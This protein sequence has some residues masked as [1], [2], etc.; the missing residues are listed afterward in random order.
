MKKC[1]NLRVISDYY[2]IQKPTGNAQKEKTMYKQEELVA[3]K[4]MVT[5]LV[6]ILPGRT[7]TFNTA[8]DD[9]RSLEEMIK[10]NANGNP[11]PGSV[12]WMLK[13][14]PDPAMWNK[15]IVHRNLPKD[16]AESYRA[17]EIRK[18]KIMGY[19]CLNSREN[20]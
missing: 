9:D 11:K 14:Y 5:K 3:E 12:Y 10:A 2:I 7:Y 13:N 6:L 4:H 20:Y 16:V 18:D 17:W 8:R 1:Y 19:H 15:F